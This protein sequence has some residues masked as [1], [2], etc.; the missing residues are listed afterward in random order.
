ML[1]C[2]VGPGRNALAALALIAVLGATVGLPAAVAAM[3][4]TEAPVPSSRPL[5]V[6]Y[7][8]ALT[9]PPGALLDVDSSRPGTGDVTLL[10]GSVTVNVRAVSVPERPEEFVA[11][12]R[13]KFERDQGLTPGPAEPLRL[14][15][16]VLGERG[17]LRPHDEAGADEPGCY[18]V[19]ASG[20]LAAVVEISPVAGCAAASAA[21]WTAVQTLTFDPE[22][23]P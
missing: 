15:N 9:P 3:L 1:G 11:H 23:Q 7:G 19:V 2:A 12:T 6:G 8:V 5:D 18:G 13:R 17:D 14:A 16:G 4:P 10:V 20:Q 22:D 21:I